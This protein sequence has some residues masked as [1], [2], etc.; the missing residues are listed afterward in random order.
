MEDK[1]DI[2]LYYYTAGQLKKFNQFRGNT[3]NYTSLEDCIAY[4]DTK[5][6][7]GR[8]QFVIVEYTDK[9]ESKIISII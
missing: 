2:R 6:L 5:I 3:H 8:W 7:S 4:I 1:R 9:Y